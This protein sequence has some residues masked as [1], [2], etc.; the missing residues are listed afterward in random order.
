MTIPGSLTAQ[1]VSISAHHPLGVSATAPLA[2]GPMFWVAE[3]ESLGC[4][5]MTVSS[6]DGT[7]SSELLGPEWHFRLSLLL[8]RLLL[9][10]RLCPFLNFI[11]TRRAEAEDLSL[12]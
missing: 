10:L 8:L 1:R 4:S 6:E 7:V 9:R 2:F 12:L 11:A 3:E 5:G